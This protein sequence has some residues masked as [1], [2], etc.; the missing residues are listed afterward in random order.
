MA[1]HTPGTWEWRDG[2]LVQVDG[3]V[4]V[5]RTGLT[6]DRLLFVQCRQPDC[7]VIAAAPDMLEALRGLLETVESRCYSD[8]ECGK[9]F[10]ISTARAAIAKA[11]G[12]A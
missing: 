6:S 10:R 2:L 8:C 11:E 5:V 3:D 7:D 12:R 4:V 1:K 9:C